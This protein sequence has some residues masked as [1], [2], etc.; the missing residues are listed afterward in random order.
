MSF[1]TFQAELAQTNSLLTRIA[2]ALERLAGPVIPPPSPPHIS[3]LSDLTVITPQ[4]QETLQQIESELAI[5]LQAI[6][7]SDAFYARMKQFEEA[8]V[9]QGGSLSDLPWQRYNEDGSPVTGNRS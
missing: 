7:G 4:D 3:T 6:P 8:V 2:V 5:H 9:A 1:L